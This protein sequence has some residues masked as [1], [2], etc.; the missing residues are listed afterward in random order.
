MKYYNN[1]PISPVAAP[2][3]V[4][5]A[6]VA[7][8]LVVASMGAAKAI[9]KV[10]AGKKTHTEA[11]NKI[12]REAL[13]TGIAMAAGAAVAKTLFRSNALGLAAMV[14]VSIGAKYAYDEML[15]TCAEKREHR[16]ESP[17]K[18]APEKPGKAKK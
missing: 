2:G 9:R 4:V 7:G 16:E 12:A 13:G 17:I 10:R 14:A 18:A 5:A 3:G 15:H 11:A 1:Y 6:G 8:A